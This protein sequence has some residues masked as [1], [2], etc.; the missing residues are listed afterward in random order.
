M[1]CYRVRGDQNSGEKKMVKAESLDELIQKGTNII[2]AI[3][4]ACMR[5]YIREM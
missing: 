4:Y 5:A 3:I 1:P 2:L